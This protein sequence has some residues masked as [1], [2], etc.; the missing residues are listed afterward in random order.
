V[1]P[2]SRWQSS[3]S[4]SDFVAVDPPAPHVTVMNSG[5]SALDI[6]SRRAR[7]FEEPI[8]VLGGKNSREK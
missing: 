1:R 8:A 2:K 6:R 5:R 3:A 4:S 7:R